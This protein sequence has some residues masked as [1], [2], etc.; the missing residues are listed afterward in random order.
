MSR[1]GDLRE[2]RCPSC[3]AGVDVLG[4]GR[5]VVQICPYCATEL[6]ATA[7][8]AA[9]RRFDGLR[10]PDTPF[11][12][13]MEGTIQGI[14]QQVIGTLGQLERHGGRSWTWVDHLLYSETHGYSWLTVEG[15]NV[16]WSRRVRW[17]LP[18]Q[19]FTTSHVEGAENRPGF[20]AEGRHWAY[21]ETST[22]AT[23]YIEGAFTWHPKLNDAVTEISYLSENEMLTVE[24]TGRERE[25]VLS[26]MLPRAEVIA[27]FGLSEDALPPFPQRH[28]LAPLPGKGNDAFMAKTGLGFLLATLVLSLV[29]TAMASTALP[30]RSAAMADLPK[31]FDIPVSTPGRL[32]RISLSAD[33]DNA[34]AGIGVELDDPEGEPVFEMEREVGYYHG[35]EGG[36]SWSEGS[37]N[38]T[39]TL[40]PEMAGTYRL[41]LTSEG[42]EVEPGYY[43]S[44]ASTIGVSVSQGQ[45][46]WLW[47][48]GAALIFGGA[49]A[50]GPARR[51]LARKM[52]LRLGDWS[53]D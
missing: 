43:G 40:R 11:R 34:W 44:V 10:R 26:V 36:E 52:R 1:S 3:G 33:V 23:T 19:M 31:V 15:G 7:N 45:P 24:A 8:F 49:A 42:G 27:A 30:Y 16:L 38:A 17:T 2:I 37:R 21:F 25:Q 9:L 47:L 41:T 20:N 4:G 14:R 29:L 6:D 5:V 51:Y 50:F 28:A 32:M 39:L 46:N 13:G 35:S 53:E 18:M 12:L 48:L 22:Y